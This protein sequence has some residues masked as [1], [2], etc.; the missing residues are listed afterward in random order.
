MVGAAGMVV[1]L[2]YCCRW[3]LVA[4]LAVGL[5]AGA[6]AGAQQLGLVPWQP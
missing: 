3:L 4:Y 2:H 1:T 5:A 6:V